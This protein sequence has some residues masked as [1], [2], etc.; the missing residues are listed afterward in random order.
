MTQKSLICADKKDRRLAPLK[1]VA[2]SSDDREDSENGVV[3]ATLPWRNH[4]IFL[5]ALA[6]LREIKLFSVDPRLIEIR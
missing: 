2:I 3:S 5:C 6:A 1:K 4:D